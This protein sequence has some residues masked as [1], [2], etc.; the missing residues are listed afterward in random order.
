[1]G[2]RRKRRSNGGRV[3]L[4][5]KPPYQELR[6]RRGARLVDNFTVHDHVVPVPRDRHSS[7][8]LAQRRHSLWNLLGG[9]SRKR[10]RSS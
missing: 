1:M 9:V 2:K 10:L 6:P 5:N 4:L 7:I 3:P 8:F